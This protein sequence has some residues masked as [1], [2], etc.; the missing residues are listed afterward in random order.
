MDQHIAV[1]FLQVLLINL[2]RHGV[3]VI[4]AVQLHTI[5]RELKFCVDS[6]SPWGMSEIHNDDGDLLWWP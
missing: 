5:K 6:I 3:A 2:W 4:S 1:Q